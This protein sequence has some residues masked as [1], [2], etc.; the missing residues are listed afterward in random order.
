MTDYA[1]VSRRTQV[2][3]M[4]AAA[5]RALAEYG[6][7]EAEL[8]LLCHEFNTTFRVTTADGQR[9]ALRMNVNS[10]HGVEAVAA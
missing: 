10:G 6:L 1:N 5:R 8:R 9:A 4:R 7:E 3:R 2:E